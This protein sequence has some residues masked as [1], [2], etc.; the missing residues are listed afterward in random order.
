MLQTT[1]LLTR[2]VV[3]KLSLIGLLS[4]AGITGPCILVITDIV[5]AS[6]APGYNMIRDSISSLA[7][8]RLG[9]IQTIGFLTIGLLVEL[10]V[11]GLFFSVRGKRG[12]GFGLA[13]LVLFGFGLLLIGAFHT[14]QSADTRTVE[15]IIHAWTAKSIFFLCPLAGL[16][17]TPTLNIEKHWKSLAKYTLIAAIFAV[18]VMASSLFLEESAW[19][20][21]F[22]RILVADE[23]IWVEF[24]AIW[25]LRLSF[26][27]KSI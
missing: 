22:E 27:T 6:S 15:G 10:F 19:F 1:N 11:A 17:M 12:F 2:P 26:K 24:M 4:L 7:W 14:S 3:S 20:G 8:T 23:V 25:L 13:A 16:L 9:F 5:A 18:I 21:L